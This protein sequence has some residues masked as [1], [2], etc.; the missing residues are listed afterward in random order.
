M[1]WGESDYFDGERGDAWIFFLIFFDYLCALLL[2]S[3]ESPQGPKTV[4]KVCGVVWASRYV[5]KATRD[6]RR[7]KLCEKKRT[8]IMTLLNREDL[9]R[10]RRGNVC[11]ESSAVVRFDGHVNKILVEGQL[12]TGMEN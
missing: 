6:T 4:S 7:E 11:D 12:L 5:G 9:D 10:L 3:D 8:I 2:R 1:V